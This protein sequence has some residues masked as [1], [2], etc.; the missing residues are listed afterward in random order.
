MVAAGFEGVGQPLEQGASVVVDGRRFAVH[1]ALGARDDPAERGRQRLV[2]EA[3]PEDR[4]PLERRVDQGRCDSG[5][6]RPTRPG[7][8]HDVGRLERQR[9]LH[10]DR[11]VTVHDRL[12]AQAGDRL[13]QVVGEGV[14]VVDQQDARR[15]AEAHSP[16][17]ASS[18]AERSTEALASTSSYSRSRVAVGDDPGSGLVAVA[19]LG[20]GE[21]AD[22]DRLVHRAAVPEVAGGT[23]V[24]AARLRLE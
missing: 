21:R 7:R 23:G 8:D 11:V 15:T 14:V 4:Q 5:V 16:S 18:M 19:P 17:S 13:H 12:G 2:P 24:D 1:Q 10:L 6:L 3:D 20:E 22:R 9:R